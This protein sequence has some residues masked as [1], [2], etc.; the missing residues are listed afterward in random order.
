MSPFKPDEVQPDYADLITSL[1]NSR[2][3]IKENALFQTI[4][5][6]LQRITKSKRLFEDDLKDLQALIDR[7]KNIT[8]ITLD[9]ETIFLPNSRRLLES[10]GIDLDDSV[11]GEETIRL[12]HYWNVLTDG[13]DPTELIFASNDAIACQ[14][15]YDDVAPFF[16]M[17]I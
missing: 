17:G 10:L 11:F 13:E 16:P 14:V 5:L 4:Y 7:F 2:S 1:V 6:L 12:T 3:Q 8:F 9:D 15:P